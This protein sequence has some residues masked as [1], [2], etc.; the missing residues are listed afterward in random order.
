MGLE[1]EVS[2]LRSKTALAGATS[3]IVFDIA[4]LLLLLL[5]FR[6]WIPSSG[7]GEG[8]DVVFGRSRAR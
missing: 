3:A 7:L 1:K 2:P 4:L 8:C 5:L 6:S